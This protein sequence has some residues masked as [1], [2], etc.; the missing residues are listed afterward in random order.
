MKVVDYPADLLSPQLR[1]ESGCACPI[2]YSPTMS[3]IDAIIDII[4]FF[5]P[6][7][8]VTS[9]LLVFVAELIFEAVIGAVALPILVLIYLVGILVTSGLRY[10]SAD[11]SEVEDLMDDIDDL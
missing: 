2:Q 5:V 3:R 1:F 7:E 4:D 10:M 9:V 8:V 6:L 11:E